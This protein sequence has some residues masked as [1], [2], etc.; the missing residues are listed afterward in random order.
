MVAR[1]WACARRHVRS[2][3][4]VANRPG[5]HHGGP[6]PRW[7]PAG[8][9]TPQLPGEQRRPQ[10]GQGPH[11]GSQPDQALLVDADDELGARIRPLRKRRFGRVCAKLEPTAVD[12]DVAWQA[13]ANTLCGLAT[14]IAGSKPGDRGTAEEMKSI[15]RARSCL[16]ARSAATTTDGGR[17]T[18]NHSVVHP[19]RKG[20]DRAGDA[21]A[22]RVSR[23]APSLSSGMRGR[24]RRATGACRRGA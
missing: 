24:H 17:R 3:I 8:G 20:L 16:C 18:N 14:P 1:S 11:P 19:A 12:P 6:T 4:A 7:S 22:E 5:S 21:G 2:G 9:P 23:R 13:E 15:L 10:R